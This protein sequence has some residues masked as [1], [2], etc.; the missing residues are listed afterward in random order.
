MPDRG[1]FGD[2]DARVALSL[3]PWLPTGT[4]LSVDAPRRVASLWAGGLPL[5]SYVLV[6]E[7]PSGT[8]TLEILPLRPADRAEIAAHSRP[9][10]RIRRR[11][12][13]RQDRDGD[14]IP[15]PV[16]VALGA[17]KAELN[18]ASYQA[19]YV[20]IPYP[21][22]DVPR[23][24]GVC[25]DVVVRSLRNA[26]FDLQRLLIVDMKKSPARY[27]LRPGRVLDRSIEH[28]RVR[29]LIRWFKAYYRVLPV[30]FE[31]GLRGSEAWLPGDVVFMDTMAGRPGP[32]HVGVVSDRLGPSGQPLIINN[33]A[34]GSHTEADD[35]LGWVP[36]THRFRIGL[37][38]R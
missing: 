36:V 31:V 25:T 11:V 2:L 26:G 3:P 8:L 34:P 29:R 30:H 37:T 20:R 33:W 17:R 12:T 32:D 21:R 1:V 23:G 7:V 15:D 13:T 27:G 4:R 9:S 38:R 22:G 18:G 16:D 14:G 5:K 28:R 24:R 19:G 6:G 10:L 35:L